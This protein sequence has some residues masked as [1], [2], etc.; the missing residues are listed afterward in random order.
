MTTQK[1]AADLCQRDIGRTIECT[2]PADGT[3]T[4]GPLAIVEALAAHVRIWAVGWLNPIRLLPGD[5]VEVTG[6]APAIG[7]ECLHGKCRACD[8]R[9]LD[10]A[11]DDIVPCTHHCHTQ[12]QTP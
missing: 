5:V 6:A 2:N 11:T 9:A 10:Q 1:Q 8:G 3:T 7:P 4:V 12:E